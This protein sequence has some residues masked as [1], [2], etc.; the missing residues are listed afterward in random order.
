[1]REPRRRR[2]FDVAASLLTVLLVGCTG[3]LPGQSPVA[4]PSPAA[5]SDAQPTPS[6][7]PAQAASP[8]PPS[9]GVPECERLDY[10]CSLAETPSEL[11]DRTIDLLDGARQA[12]HQGTMA[13]ALAFLEAEPDV[14]KAR[15]NDDAVVFR[16]DGAPESWLID[17]SDTSIEPASTSNELASPVGVTLASARSVVP[18]AEPPR[19]QQSVVG[20]DT[21]ND[22][23]IDNRDTKRALVLAPYHWQFAPWDESDLLAERLSTLPG[24]AGNVRYVANLRQEDR[25]VTL[26]DYQHFDAYDAIFVS[27]HGRRVCYSD[28]CEVVV[29]TGVR[30]DRDELPASLGTRTLG[31]YDDK[32]NQQTSLEVY[33]G[34]LP[35]TFQAWYPGGLD[36]T[37]LVFSACQTG[38]SAGNELAAAAA[39]DNFVMMGWSETVPADAAFEATGFFQEQLGLGLSSREAYG[40]VV[41]AG[42]DRSSS[43]G[44][45]TFFEYISPGGDDLRLFELPTVYRDGEPLPGGADVTDLITGTPGD[46]EPDQLSLELRLAGVHEPG[47]YRIRYEIDGRPTPGTYDLSTGTEGDLRYSYIVR[48]DVDVGFDLKPGELT[49]EAI[50]ELPEGGESRYFVS[51]T[52]AAYACTLIDTATLNAE[53]GTGFDEFEEAPYVNSCVWREPL[54]ES[55]TK[56][57]LVIIVWTEASGPFL[58]AQ[59]E[60][61][62][63]WQVGAPLPAGIEAAYYDP[64][65]TG[66]PS[67]IELD[68]GSVSIGAHANFHFK[69]I[70]MWL[71]LQPSGYLAVEPDVE[72]RL[73]AVAGLIAQELA[74]DAEGQ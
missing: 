24:Y 11:L 30:L 54:F 48:H 12:R 7:G 52:V 61:N 38:G 29:S 35:I 70:G 72:N 50:V 46:S 23:K 49:I 39:G 14:V 5:T 37:L 16:V 8:A 34:L 56:S 74:G 27:T 67:S 19:T 68:D 62:P 53:L 4:D 69:T 60:A 33:V 2:A 47:S 65:T 59:M 51:A 21:N 28:G 63:D 64:G 13:D 58:E 17:S 32:A 41:E 57:S 9:D 66:N 25:N 45:P 15:G 26:L 22:S 31:H 1:M 18:S 10:P 40:A 20:T 36:D 55:W 3:A 73:L 71:G 42:L 6:A 44:V 43:K